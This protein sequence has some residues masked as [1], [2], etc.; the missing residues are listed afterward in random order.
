MK[1]AYFRGIGIIAVI[2]GMAVMV[3]VAL[4]SYYPNH[5]TLYYDGNSYADSWLL[6]DALGPWQHNDP[7]YEHDLA[8]KKYYF[9]GCTSWTNLPA[10]YDDCPT[11]GVSENG[12]MWSF[13]FG[14]FHAKRIQAGTWYFGFWSL[15][16]GTAS[17]T[18]FYLNGQENYHGFCP[19]DS[20]WCM[21][22]SRTL[23]LLQGDFHL[24]GEYRGS[25]NR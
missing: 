23:H 12:D 2:L 25:W 21:K 1:R 13:T 7:G 22:A 15:E 17:T 10:G 5:G 24:G 14:T 11:A 4:A 8:A 16:R 18:H 20:I 6:W 19:W 9:K 3:D